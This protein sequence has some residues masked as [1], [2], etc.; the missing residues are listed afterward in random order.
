MGF[1]KKMDP[2]TNRMIDLDATY[3]EIIKPAVQEL[4]YQCV[5][6][7]EIVENGLIDKSMYMLLFAADIVIADISTANPN[8]IFE[9]G[10]R[11]VCKPTSTI[12]I[13]ENKGQFPFDLNH[14]RVLSYEHLGNK[15]TD[16]EAIKTREQ[17][18][19]R[20]MATGDLDSP[21]Y[22]FLSSFKV[23]PP[24]TEDKTIRKICEEFKTLENSIFS[25]SKRASL[26]M[27]EGKMDK[28]QEIWR[29]LAEMVQCE[30]YYKQQEALCCYKNKNLD[31]VIAA[32]NAL[33]I[34]EALGGN[35]L[36]SETLGMI[37]SCHKIIYKETRDL[38]ELMLAKQY[39]EK[40]W[41]LY[42]DYYNGENIANCYLYLAEACKNDKNKYMEYFQCAKNKYAEV[43]E[44]AKH[45]I[46]E[47]PEDNM[48]TNATIANCYYALGKERLGRTFETKFM[49]SVKQ[50]WQRE[51]FENTKHLILNYYGK[52]L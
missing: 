42:R 33:K 43:L 28:A 5:R 18:K 15:I 12:V 8:A 52:K 20:I 50:D 38:Q 39:Y 21:F 48:W 26:Y 17:L 35:S 2:S 22:E 4:G 30:T 47:E 51:T 45:K 13:Q 32:K 7:D 3:L 10:V 11:Y 27:D 46:K 36:D 19:T 24:K 49:L 44:V 29:N 6:A 1:G 34:L 16:E 25:L 41:I 9:L 40:S 14:I 37:G 23:T 31:R